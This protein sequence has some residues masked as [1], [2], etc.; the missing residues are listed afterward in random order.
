MMGLHNLLSHCNSDR[1]NGR[2][3]RNSHLV[4]R[5][6]VPETE[7]GSLRLRSQDEHGIQS[8][9]SREALHRAVREP[10][11]REYYWAAVATTSAGCKHTRVNN[12]NLV[13]WHRFST[14]D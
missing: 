12:F 1:G 14:A 6:E 7:V 10:I 4:I 11:S 8:K 2:M 3:P 13:R 5:N 9:P